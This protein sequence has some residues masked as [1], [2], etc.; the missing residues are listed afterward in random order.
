MERAWEGAEG[1][2][3]LD[4]IKLKELD[5][6]SRRHFRAVI[7]MLPE[8]QYRGDG[9]RLHRRQDGSE[10]GVPYWSFHG[11]DVTPCVRDLNDPLGSFEVLFDRD[12]GLPPTSADVRLVGES[13]VGGARV[14]VTRLTT[15]EGR[16]FVV[17]QRHAEARPVLAR[18]P[19]GCLRWRTKFYLH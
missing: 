14:L 17:L 13:F 4:S 18:P 16:P 19:R 10:T 15:D 3:V 8:G 5:E 6:W 12:D 2:R 7:A 1:G 11:L 9:P